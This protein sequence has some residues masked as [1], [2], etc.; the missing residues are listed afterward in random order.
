[1]SRCTI[2]VLPASNVRVVT[3]ARERVGRIAAAPAGYEAD[4]QSGTP[5]NT[6]NWQNIGIAT[7]DD[8]RVGF[9]KIAAF[10]LTSDKLPPAMLA[11]NDHHCVLALL[12]HRRP[13]HIDDDQH[14]PELPTGA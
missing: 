6:G 1:M 4:V 8:V 11:G 10:D 13:V 3:L 5:I 12:H 7:L 9:P 2:A 14:R